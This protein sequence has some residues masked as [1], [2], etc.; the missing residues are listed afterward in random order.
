MKKDILFEFFSKEDL[1]KIFPEEI[2]NHM[3]KMVQFNVNDLDNQ[4]IDL[5]NHRHKINQAITSLKYQISLTNK[6]IKKAEFE[7]W[8]R[9]FSEAFKFQNNNERKLYIETDNKVME[10]QHKKDVFEIQLDFL[11]R[12]GN[13]LESKHYMIKNYLDY[14]AWTK[15][16]K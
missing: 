14:L 5:M 12:L 11:E 2:L 8:K 16:D 4:M 3:N 1:L 7:V 13:L 10:F 15:G 9:S 6:K